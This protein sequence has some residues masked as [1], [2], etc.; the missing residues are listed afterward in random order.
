M[1]VV[2]TGEHTVLAQQVNAKDQQ[3]ITTI[4]PPPDEHTATTPPPTLPPKQMTIT[5]NHNCSSHSAD[6]PIYLPP[7]P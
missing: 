2:V 1:D 6:L 4:P 5:Y 7:L 3:H